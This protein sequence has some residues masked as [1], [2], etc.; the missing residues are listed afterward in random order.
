MELPSAPAVQRNRDAILAV[1]AT[2]FSSARKVLE[3]G[4][5]TGEHA[6]YFG[7]KLPGLS[8]QTSDRLTNH[9]AIEGWIAHA[10]LENVLPPIELDVAEPP[11]LPDAPYDGVFSANT[12]HIMSEAEVVEMFR[13]VGAALVSGGRFCLYGPFTTRGDFNAESNRQFDASLRAQDPA[14]GIRDLY[15]LHELATNGD[16]VSR[17]VH[18][19]PA[20]NCLAVWERR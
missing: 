6:I 9:M 4:S 14:M 11:V 13:L 10:G 2:E 20:N 15:W 8:W 17:T 19:L 5:G 18:P 3:I 16:M 1:L 12:A 7:A